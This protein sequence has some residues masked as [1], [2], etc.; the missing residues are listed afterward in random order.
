MT[1]VMKRLIGETLDFDT[2]ELR[3][4]LV[5]LGNGSA[6]IEIPVD[7]DTAHMLVQLC[8]NESDVAVPAPIGDVVSRPYVEHAVADDDDPEEY[9]ED[10]TGVG[11]I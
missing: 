9:I 2:G 4:K 11:S 7:D 8:M 10:E 5:V 6:E 3:P 1:V